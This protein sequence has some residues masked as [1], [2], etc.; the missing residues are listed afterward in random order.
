MVL[1]GVLLTGAAGAARA[2]DSAAAVRD[3]TRMRAPLTSKFTLRGEFLRSLPVDDPRD[4]LALYPGVVSRDDA[5][6]VLGRGDAALRGAAPGEASVYVDGAPARRWLFGTDGIVPGLAAIEEIVVTTGVPDASVAD[7]R[8]GVIAYMIR[9]GGAS[10]AGDFRATSDEP[11]GDGSTVG[12]NTFEGLLGGPL[13][14]VRG[15]TW[16]FAGVAQGQRSHYRSSRAADHPLFVTGATDTVVTDTAGGNPIALP[17]YVQWSGEC[18]AVG[19]PDSPVG[20]DIQGNYGAECHGLGQAMDWTSALRLHGKLTFAYGAGGSVSLTGLTA[21]LQERRFPG[22]VIGAPTLFRGLRASSS[23]FVA[24][25][26]HP[27]RLAGADAGVRVIL[28]LGDDESI[29]G[30]LAPASEAATRDPALGIEFGTLR[31]EGEDILPVPI[32]ET[33]VRN[34][35]TNSGLRVPYL[36]RSDLANVQP[37]RLNPYGLIANGW[38]TSGLGTTL[39]FGDERRLHGSASLQWQPVAGHHVVLGGDA[40]RVNASLY[41]SHMLEQVGMDAFILSSRRWGIYASDEVAFGATVLSVG[42]RWDRFTS[43]ARYPRT[44]GRLFTHPRYVWLD[45]GTN[46]SAYAAY[47]ADDSIWTYA[48]PQSELSP[49]LSAAYRLGASAALRASY[50]QHIETPSLDDLNR[51]ANLDLAYAPTFFGWGRDVAYG[52]VSAA[53]LGLRHAVGDAVTMDWAVYRKAGLEMYGLRFT[54]FVD[55][56]D[57]TDTL[58]VPALQRVPGSTAT[59]VDIRLDW[60]RAD[61]LEA[62]FGYAL[63]HRSQEFGEPLTTQS[64]TGV[65]GL[66]VPEESA[67]RSGLGAIARGM[68]GHVTLRLTSGRQYTRLANT[69]A[70]WTL[71]DGLGSGLVNGP[72]NGARL[73][74]TKHLDLRVDKRWQTAG[75]D[76]RVFL[77]ARNILGLANLVDIFTE[78]GTTENV[79]HRSETIGDPFVG[80]REYGQLWY[81]AQVAGAL[82]SDQTIDLRG[83]C[84]SWPEPVNCTSLVRVENRFGDGDGLYTVAEQERAFNAFYDSFFGPSRFYEAGRTLRLGLDIA[85]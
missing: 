32:T 57:P 47:L 3:T 44:P 15:S 42:L 46:D 37:W 7:A 41:S 54:K 33:I 40:D 76:W 68:S 74:W 83:N 50:G 9:D 60:R 27:L 24:N 38:Y 82:A 43:D 17:Q 70:G 84:Q 35:R 39:T 64:V 73:P 81:E 28:S 49:R 85:F 66:T 19:N 12:Y 79:R 53:E 58:M 8:G 45:A 80:S 20:R 11:F 1:V 67:S 13:P 31:F 16:F 10:V 56:A 34:V 14:G 61:W 25:W 52:K 29:T 72:I 78:T 26:R 22:E 30:A 21:R 59:G 5:R 75:L 18:G 69:G 65:V 51:G 2:Q 71:A 55:P 63:E 23:M 62:T 77:D 36:G 6:G 4:A 48:E